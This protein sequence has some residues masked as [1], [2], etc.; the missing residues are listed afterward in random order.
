MT[1]RGRT[2]KIRVALGNTKIFWST[3]HK[4]I[5]EVQNKIATFLTIP[6]LWHLKGLVLLVKSEN[7]QELTNKNH[8]K[9]AFIHLGHQQG[10]F[11]NQLFALWPAFFFIN[12]KYKSEKQRQVTCC[13]PILNCATIK[14]R[15]RRF[16]IIFCF[17]KKDTIII[18]KGTRQNELLKVGT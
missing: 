4:Q 17:K 1:C 8:H 9:C 2:Y 18:L 5:D 12:V 11:R 14:K 15:G 13:N 10:N 16:K 7:W 3:I 6:L